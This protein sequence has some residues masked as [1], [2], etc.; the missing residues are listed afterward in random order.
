MLRAPVAAAVV[1]LLT[2]PAQARQQRRDPPLGYEEALAT[3]RGGSV[4]GAL[5]L[6]STVSDA[7]LADA[8]ELVW[9]GTGLPP[10]LRMGRIRT[11]VAMHT[12]LVFRRA[13][14]RRVVSQDP[15]M[16][17]ARS[18]VRRL[19]RAA[20]EASDG[21]GAAEGR[22]ARD[23]YLLV[24]SF[25]HGRGEV[26]WSR[27]YLDEARDLFP[28]DPQVLLVSGTDREML[29]HLTAGYLTQF[30]TSGETVGESEINPAREL[31]E[32][33]RFLRQAA[34]RAPDLVEPRL[35]LGRVLYRRGDL[36]GAT[37]ELR[38]ALEQ[39]GHDQARYLQVRYLAWVFLGMVEVDRGDLA[40]A[41]RCYTEALSLFPEGQAALL[42]MSEASY[43]D[44]RGAEAA[45]EVV[46]LLRLRRK[47]DPWWGYLLGDWWHFETRLAMLRA[48]GM[49]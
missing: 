10:E 49:R 21:A 42:A 44:G 45:S 39:T 13:P 16:T 19:A 40:A 9:S 28:D 33:E 14:A 27:A 23:W 41:R 11:A 48:E 20:D 31:G 15:S 37:K 17:V 2:F 4:L 8:V 36:A 22:F 34:Q 3:Y 24:A 43:L 30:R 1:I 25:W 12:E 6:L 32:A 35:R 46:S 29:S 26:G 18:L 5:G 47:E 38:A 7:Q